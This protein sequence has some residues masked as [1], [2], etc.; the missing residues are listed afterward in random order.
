MTKIHAPTVDVEII[1]KVWYWCVSAYKECG[2]T[3][4]FP[5]CRDITKTYQWRY[6][7][8]LAEQF[9]EWEFDD[10]TSIFFIGC[11]AKYARGKG[12]LH[13]GL[14]AFFQSNI[15]D[16]CYEHIN[17][18]CNKLDARLEQLKRNHDFLLS[19][20][21]GR[22][23]DAL[24]RRVSLDSYYNIVRWY[25]EDNLSRLYLAVSKPCVV[26]VA[27]I[28]KLNTPQCALLPTTTELFCELGQFDNDQHFK[29]QAAQ[30]LGNHWRSL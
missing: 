12:L 17:K 23:V 29:K 27:R 21:G 6:A 14:S 7:T 3:L 19:H 30:I 15:I 22:P 26:A 2:R 5:D 4:K 10:Q 11:V 1:W 9:E 20:S 24:L 28:S 25:E 16:V 13:K 8:K 18:E